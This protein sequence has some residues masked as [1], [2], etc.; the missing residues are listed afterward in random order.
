MSQY[1]TQCGTENVNDA[2]FCKSCGHSLIEK[3]PSPA[4]EQEV[5]HTEPTQEQEAAVNVEENTVSVENA[6]E[7]PTALSGWLLLIPVVAW[8]LYKL[9]ILAGGN[10]V[11]MFGF[12]TVPNILGEALGGAV[13]IVGA[14]L[15]V[16]GLIY[17]VKKANGV[18]YTNFVLHTLIASIVLLAIGI[19]GS[20][21]TIRDE[22]K[23]ATVQTTS[24]VT[25]AEA[26]AADAAA[27]DAAAPA[28]EAA[29]VLSEADAAIPVKA[30]PVLSTAEQ[31]DQ[32][33]D[34]GQASKYYDLGRAYYIGLNG[35]LKDLTKALE[36]YK[37]SCDLGSAEGCDASAALYHDTDMQKAKAYA[38]KAIALHKKDCNRG[39]VD[40]CREICNYYNLG[41][42]VNQDQSI[43]KVYASKEFAL[44]K[45][46]CDRG[47]A[48]ECSETGQAY[49]M[50]IGVQQDIMQ[51][52]N[53]LRNSCNSGNG[54]GCRQLG[55]A[56]YIGNNLEKD[57]SKAAQYFKKACDIY[58]NTYGCDQYEELQ[59]QGY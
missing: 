46:A 47:D 26:P 3:E 28:A 55:F 56:Y 19:A 30:A 51:G 42:Y 33:Y 24:E 6:M 5:V 36:F 22:Q 9:G 27:V 50:G 34:N 41:D 18:Q 23:A 11:L 54:Y 43:V 35:M 16:T 52:K 20:I 48:E 39:N 10:I 25:D 2:K 49:L 29:P 38:L 57:Y 53:V 59:K 4:P 31:L 45:K 7:E 12:M 58:G 44:H 1:C 14:P 37:K 40:G 32:D 8:V 15:I 13:G 17:G 21:N